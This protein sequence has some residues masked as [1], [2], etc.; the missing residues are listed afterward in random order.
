MKKI[1]AGIIAFTTVFCT[2][3][4]CGSTDEKRSD[5]NDTSIETTTE[6]TDN[7]DMTSKTSESNDNSEKTYEDIINWYV[8]TLN[9]KDITK[10]LEMQ[11]PDGCEKM[12]EIFQN[13][14]QSDYETSEMM[15][16]YAE[17][18]GSF[19][20][21]TLKEIVSIEALNDDESERIKN[22]CAGYLVLEERIKELGELDEIDLDELKCEINEEEF[23]EKLNSIKLNDARLVTINLKDEED[24]DFFTEE[25][26]YIY[27]INDGN[28]HI[29][30]SLFDYMT[31]SSK[32]SENDTARSL[33]LAVNTALVEL[34]EQS[35]GKLEPIMSRVL[36]CSDESKN[37]NTPAG[38]EYAEFIKNLDNYFKNETKYDWFVVIDEMYVKYA[39]IV[40]KNQSQIGI[41]PYPGKL[42]TDLETDNTN[43]VSG[44]SFDEVYDM[45]AEVL[46]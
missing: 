19:S 6:S 24:D 9:S 10:Y 20:K 27:R 7:T 46:K 39:V 38:F 26:F 41:S 13:E 32:G 28:W 14:I 37:I 22:A 45:C 1:L 42:G 25:K 16:G 30:D 12:A 36:I 31:R 11:L 4:G 8:D 3:T 15:D 35:N 5:G 34:E 33:E 21:Y 43:N 44:K 17:L 23:S 18:F 40:K 2:F 29:D